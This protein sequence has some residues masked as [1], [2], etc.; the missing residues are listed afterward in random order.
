MMYLIKKKYRDAPPNMKEVIKRMN[1]KCIDKNRVLQ[2][3]KNIRP[4]NENSTG[5]PSANP[6][7]DTEGIAQT[8]RV[9]FLVDSYVANR[10]V[11]LNFKLTQILHHFWWC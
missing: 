6:T 7:G 8:M 4:I 11:S 5:N 10:Y 9:R 2:K 1:Q 3:R